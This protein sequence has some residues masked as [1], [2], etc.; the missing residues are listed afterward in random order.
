MLQIMPA[1][2]SAVGGGTAAGIG[3]SI[4]AGLGTAGSF[5]GNLGSLASGIGGLFGGGKSS[6]QKFAQFAQ[7]EGFRI[8]KDLAYNGIF[9][10]VQDAKQSGIHP[11]YALGAPTYNSSFS[12]GDFGSSG[13]ALSDLGAA[14]QNIGAALH[15]MST[16]E[17]RE[18]GRITAGLAV[19]R[20]HLENELLKSQIAQIQ[21]SINPAIPTN[22]QRQIIPG[23]QDSMTPAMYDKLPT[24]VGVGGSQPLHVMAVDENGDVFPVYNTNGLG[25]NEMA[26]AAHFLRYSVPSYIDAKVARPFRRW[27]GRLAGAVRNSYTGRR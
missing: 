15:R 7:E 17:D 27:Y 12:A 13:G 1:L 23:Q 19:E 4:M 21:A 16:P 6:A 24:P 5:L 18:L 3:S 8:Q 26:Q 10:R 14:G 25:D 20:G 9:H 11:L 2:M 22:T